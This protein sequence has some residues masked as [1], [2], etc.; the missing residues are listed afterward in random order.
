MIAAV[1]KA[2]NLFFFFFFLSAPEV[3]LSP[4]S[5]CSPVTLFQLALQTD[6]H[7]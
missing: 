6:D 2:G 4:V 7:D 1:L 5:G 3:C